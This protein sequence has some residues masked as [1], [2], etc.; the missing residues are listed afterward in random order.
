MTKICN[1]C[2]CEKSREAF[3]VDPRC[4]NGRGARCRE[5]R[6]EYERARAPQRHEYHRSEARRAAC[7]AAAEGRTSKPCYKC[8]FER[9]FEEFPRNPSGLCGLGSWCKTCMKTYQQANM[10]AHLTRERSE[11]YKEKR[12]QNAK[13]RRKVDARFRLQDNIRNRFNKVL[14]G[15]TKT[16]SALLLLGCSVDACYAHLEKQFSAGMTWDNWGKGPGKWNIDHIRPVASFSDLTDPEQLC[17][18]FHYTNF[19]PM[20]EPDNLRKGANYRG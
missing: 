12:R 15:K 6:K 17:Q 13:R 14:R 4:L 16:S 5:C 3:L 19:Q 20:W 8:G 9:L 7:L 2:F 11:P 18:C 10:A 1:K